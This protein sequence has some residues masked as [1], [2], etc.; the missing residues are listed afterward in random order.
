LKIYF[1]IIVNSAAV[2]AVHQ[3][4][5]VLTSSVKRSR[6]GTDDATPAVATCSPPAEVVVHHLL[7]RLLLSV[8]LRRPTPPSTHASCS[9]PPCLQ[10]VAMHLLS[11]LAGPRA[12]TRVLPARRPRGSVPPSGLSSQ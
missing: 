7:R 12:A 2:R 9:P 1:K 4:T 8:V 6:R 10:A 5:L 3:A 11:I